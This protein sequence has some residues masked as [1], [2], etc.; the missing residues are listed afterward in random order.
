MRGPAAKFSERR[1]SSMSNSQPP[2]PIPKRGAA[3]RL[4][5]TLCALRAHCGAVFIA[6]GTAC[7][8]FAALTAAGVTAAPAPTVDG[9][10]TLVFT[11]D[12]R[13]FG[14]VGDGQ[15]DDTAAF[16]KALDAASEAGGGIVHAPAGQYR[17]DG[18]LLVPPA[19]TLRGEWRDP[20]KGGSGKG[21]ILLV[22]E[23]RGNPEG[24]YFLSV[25]NSSCVRDL[26]FFYPEQTVK[27]IQPYPYTIGFTSQY[28]ASPFCVTVRN[29]TLM[30]SYNGID[31]L[32]S[33]A[34]AR[35]MG[36]SFLHFFE[37]IRGTP[38]NHGISM[39]ACTDAGRITDCAFSPEY[40][41]NCGLP[42]PL[43][44]PDE[45]AALRKHLLARGRGFSLGYSDTEH[46]TN[47]RVTGYGVGIHLGSP[48][49]KGYPRQASYG[50]MY[51]LAIEGCRVGIQADHVYSPI[52]Y[53]VTAS[54]IVALERAVSGGAAGLLRFQDCV[55][56]EGEKAEYARSAAN[57]KIRLASHR[58]AS[59]PTPR[60]ARVVNVRQPPYNALGNGK[61][62]DA[63]AF[64]AALNEL[65][66]GGGTVFLP[67][68][69]YRIQ[70]PLTVPAGVELRGI[71][72]GIAR[73]APNTSGT[74]LW[75]CVAEETKQPAPFITLGDGSGVRGIAI[76]YPEQTPAGRAFPWTI[77]GG[78]EG[79]YVVRCT[80][81]NPSYGIDFGSLP[82]RNHLV[83]HVMMTPVKVGIFVARAEN[84]RIEDYH[85]HPQFW[86]Y[87]VPNWPN[88]P[89]HRPLCGVNLRIGYCRNQLVV[90]HTTWQSVLGTQFTDEGAD[91]SAEQPTVWFINSTT[92]SSP[93][94]A[95]GGKHEVEVVNHQI[96]G[97]PLYR[98][99]RG[100]D[101]E[102]RFFN[103]IADQALQHMAFHAAVPP[104]KGELDRCDS[105]T[106]W[107]GPGARLDTTDHKEG[108]ACLSSTTQELGSDGSGWFA[109]QFIS[110]IDAGVTEADGALRM[111]LY[112]S[113]TTKLVREGQIE[114]TSSGG[115]D[116]DEYAWNL[117]DMKL[118]N[119][120]NDLTLPFSQA[121][122]SGKPD[123]RNIRYF[124]IYC[125]LSGPITRRLDHIR[126]EKLDR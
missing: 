91:A 76:F 31:V 126:I 85:V 19:V 34:G 40:W 37:Q 21:T 38:L 89:A 124:R 81:A 29:V 57:E 60:S 56:R 79:C 25:E 26:T 45:W 125:F 43:V 114:I 109:R 98:F 3:P 22:Y 64:Q 106:G 16:Q 41:E 36:E 61:N 104:V 102:A 28:R 59:V 27:D 69:N 77:R 94:F 49:R 84:G 53:A 103:V 92:D 111:W 47:I 14:A 11:H 13:D 30:N 110:W 95:L 54:R 12:V 72:E 32:Q 99:E 55:F 119:G 73:P 70:S 116:R 48:V 80:L 44:D 107:R 50:Q 17:C 15:S 100:Y 63:P 52:G 68:G 2:N 105:L 97:R 35:V 1:Q 42:G 108:K 67:A 82:N 24:K 39:G 86:T 78:G 93:A 120:W 87:H 23:N 101:G 65:K 88:R 112:V 62:D 96:L 9:A 58:F 5:D 20:D 122:K 121:S 51:G 115:Y 4:H 46:L 74:L 75:A 113:D 83:S 117:L 71:W 18:H 118:D 6:R 33:P 66:D 90:N 7:L 8:L 10:E 123:L